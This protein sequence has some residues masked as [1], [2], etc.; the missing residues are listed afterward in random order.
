VTN[1]R[2]FS[3]K[4][5]APTH[6]HNNLFKY[7]LL[8]NSVMSEKAGLLQKLSQD[9][10]FLDNLRKYNAEIPPFLL[11]TR[12]DFEG[13][14]F[15]ELERF[16]R[17]IES[18]KIIVRSAHPLEERF[19]GGTFSSYTNQE[20][21]KQWQNERWLPKNVHTVLSLRDKIIHDARYAKSLSIRRQ[22]K[23]D[24]APIINPDDIG[25]M[26]MPFCSGC[27][28]M[29]KQLDGEWEY[30]YDGIIISKVNYRSLSSVDFHGHLKDISELIQDKIGLPLEIEYVWDQKHK[31]V[32]VVQLRGISRFKS[33]HSSI[34]PI[35]ADTSNICSDISICR[36]R[37]ND[38][39]V[40]TRPFYVIDEE[41]EFWTDER[42]QAT[43]AMPSFSINF[44]GFYK[45][46]IDGL[47]ERK[48]RFEK[49]AL[50][51]RNFGIYL[52]NSSFTHQFLICSQDHERKL[53]AELSIGDIG[54]DSLNY[55]GML[56][57]PFFLEADTVITPSCSSITKH[58]HDAFGINNINNP[59]WLIMLYSDGYKYAED[60]LKDI[61]T[62]TR[63]KIQIYKKR[64]GLIEAERCILRLD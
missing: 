43:L 57:Y 37:R 54:G 31:I 7:S 63:V 46:A 47:L 51:H 30:G 4:P 25:A 18:D 56:Y 34:G 23:F 44:E 52:K 38:E 8:F 50:E 22:Q 36:A 26:V 12:S 1:L 40:R 49:F 61:K 9:R 28:V 35:V 17:L 62:G 5:L 13:S 60:V 15:G 10:A 3:E 48:E 55:C 2:K 24:G 16:L 53:P 27:R 58:A 19:K 45:T 14:N 33:E 20:K 41:K 11:F 59:F 39:F 21:T 64:M 42:L 6:N 32:Y 29:V